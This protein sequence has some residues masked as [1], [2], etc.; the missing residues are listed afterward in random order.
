MNEIESRLVAAQARLPEAPPVPTA[1]REAMERGMRALSASQR[2]RRRFSARRR[3]IGGALALA[4]VLAI[5]GLAAAGV[6]LFEVPDSAKGRLA[7]E[8]GV[9]VGSV[10]DGTQDVLVAPGAGS[11]R[12][13]LCVTLANAMGPDDVS[14]VLCQPPSRSDTPGYEYAERRPGRDSWALHVRIPDPSDPSSAIVTEYVIPAA[15]GVVSFRS[16]D[17]QITRTYP[18]TAAADARADADARAHVR[19]TL[20]AVRASIAE[21]GRAAALAGL[22]AGQRDAL[23]MRVIEE[24]DYP[25]IARREGTSVSEARARV[26]E[27]LRALGIE[28]NGMLP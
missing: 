16:G 24:L 25:E 2:E 21:P 28:M 4:G 5:G 17:R 27:A 23:E 19:R 15:G 8:Q 22:P 10:R 12:G 13:E 14:P 26:S 7:P 20:A 6:T 18:N 9:V 3:R 11:E 1:A